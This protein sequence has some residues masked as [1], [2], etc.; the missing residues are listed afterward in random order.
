MN[1]TMFVKIEIYCKGNKFCFDDIR[2]SAKPNIIINIDAISSLGSE[3]DFGFCDEYWKYPY[4]VLTMQNG[5]MYICTLE[6]GNE[7]E[8][9]LSTI[10]S[11]GTNT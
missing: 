8:K 7:L 11:N 1:I 2:T 4:R 9:I 5:D 3:T 6:S 10:Q